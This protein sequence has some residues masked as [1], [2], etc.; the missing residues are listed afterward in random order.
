MR[1]PAI[2]TGDM[3]CVAFLLERGNTLV[4]AALEPELGGGRPFQVLVE[5]PCIEEDYGTYCSCLP[6]SKT[7]LSKAFAAILDLWGRP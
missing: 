4:S 3:A 2:M 1:A 6:F 5:G 7:S